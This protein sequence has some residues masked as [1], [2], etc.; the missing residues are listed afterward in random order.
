MKFNRTPPG[1]SLTKECE[2]MSRYKLS[3][4][5]AV[6]A[7]LFAGFGSAHVAA[8]DAPAASADSPAVFETKMELRDLWV[9]HVFWIRSYVLATQAGDEAQRQVAET[10]VVSNAKALAGTIAPFYGQAAAD[11]LLTLLAGHWGAVRDFNTA[12]VRHSEAG[13][14]QATQDLTANAHEIAKFLSGANPYLPEDAVFGLLAAHGAHHVAQIDQI[15][16]GDFQQEAVTWQAMRTHM[17]VIADAIAGALAKQFP[18]RF[19][20]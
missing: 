4:L 14:I 8:A 19:Y 5:L 3:A 7:L 6:P 11:G 15:T 16:A 12:T 9:E 18:D 1:A 13:R 17:L 2:E 10:E 20:S